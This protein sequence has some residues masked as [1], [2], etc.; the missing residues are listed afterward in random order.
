[1]LLGEGCRTSAAASVHLR[2]RPLLVET[3]TFLHAFR[4]LARSFVIGF[5]AVIALISGLLLQGDL[6]RA[7]AGE[8]RRILNRSAAE[9]LD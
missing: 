2:L 3:T 1:M 6:A 9:K 5:F 4:L 8:I 7:W